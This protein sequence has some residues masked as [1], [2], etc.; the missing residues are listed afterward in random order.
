M[1]YSAIAFI[2]I[3]FS[4]SLFSKSKDVLEIL[5][6]VSC[7][8]AKWLLYF[9]LVIILATVLIRNWRIYKIF[10]NPRI[11]EKKYLSNKI[12]CLSIISL[13]LPVFI[14]LA[15]WTGVD[16]Y[17]FHEEVDSGPNKCPDLQE[18]SENINTS[19]I[20]YSCRTEYV[21]WDGSLIIYFIILSIGLIFLSLQNAKIETH[22]AQEGDFAAK[23]VFVIFLFLVPFFITK[24]VLVV[25]VN[26]Q[27]SRL[28]FWLEL[29]TTTAFPTVII[30][31]LFIPKV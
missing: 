22:F 31:G 27:G 25:I 12:M 11:E 7:E 10:Y 5:L 29:I 30:G 4:D 21:G 6:P 19:H 18:L 3:S 20:T 2:P 9:G 16:H 23:A 14:L 28:L 24:L 8:L 17:K 1:T 15:V 26:E 13:V